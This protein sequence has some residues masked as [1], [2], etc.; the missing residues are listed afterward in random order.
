[1][2]AVRFSTIADVI[3][4]SPGLP[5]GNLILVPPSFTSARREVCWWREAAMSSPLQPH[6]SAAPARMHGRVC[7]R[8]KRRVAFMVMSFK[9]GKGLFL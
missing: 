5:D 3:R 9:A 8:V 6:M 2:V 1:M 7:I 4:L